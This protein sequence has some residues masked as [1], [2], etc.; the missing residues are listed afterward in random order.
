[1]AI[2]DP[3]LLVALRFTSANPVIRVDTGTA[4]D[5]TLTVAADTDYWMSGNG[6]GDLAQALED[7]LNTNTD[8]TVFT[9][10]LS[11]RNVVTVT[12]DSAF[13]ILWSHANT[14]VDPALFGFVG[15]TASAT[16]A[17]APDAAQGCWVPSV[18][19]DHPRPPM[20]DTRRQPVVRGVMTS[21]ISGKSRSYNL[22]G[23][24]DL[25]ERRIRWHEIKR[26]KVLTEYAD[27]ADPYGA[28]EWWW[29][30]GE[31][32]S[33]TLRYYED[34][35]NRSSYFVC[36]AAELTRPWA[37]DESR[38][39]LRYAVDLRLREIEGSVSGAAE[40]A[41]LRYVG[42]DATASS[43]S[44]VVGASLAS[45]GTAQ[46]LNASTSGI[47]PAADQ[48]DKAVQGVTSGGYVGSVSW[49]A[50]TYTLRVLFY[51]TDDASGQVV[52]RW[53]Q[54][55]GAGPDYYVSVQHVSAATVY[56]QISDV[57][58]VLA[59]ALPTLS[60][61][62][63]LV[64]LIVRPTGGSLGVTQIQAYLDG[65]DLGATDLARAM[66]PTAVSTTGNL[67]LLC[68][69]TGAATPANNR[70]QE[71][72]VYPGEMALADHQAYAAEQGL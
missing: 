43:W 65:A 46:T 8:G 50:T 66:D 28:L 64:D 35:T 15:D 34:K 68:D 62:W 54:Y 24:G 9:V 37:E 26:E 36:R 53:T 39:Q 33:R 4:Q 42:R 12:G 69:E 6:S 10:T 17:V 59:Y 41:L 5:V 27:T 72:A 30:T 61:G 7:A 23:S 44:G 14:T 70:L 20:R 48:I 18:D 56:L 13:Q 32:C 19:D 45:V 16:S 71:F 1:V 21:T 22:S 2:A 31:A 3:I 67:S 52:G 38:I 29:E 49:P 11:S 25:G 57:V 58:G 40:T 51:F 63:H 55:L 60:V 47:T